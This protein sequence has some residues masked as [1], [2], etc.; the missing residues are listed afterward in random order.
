MV[1]PKK[2]SNELMICIR[3]SQPPNDRFNSDI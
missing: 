3:K 2:Q 1:Q